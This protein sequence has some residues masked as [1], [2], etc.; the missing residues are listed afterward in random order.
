MFKFHIK[1]FAACNDPHHY[2]SSNPID[3][4]VRAETMVEAL[5][6]AENALGYKIH[7][8]TMTVTVEED[9]SINN[10]QGNSEVR[11]YL[12]KIAAL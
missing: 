11:A 1:G 5:V 12:K 6:K 7:R 3:I 2:S 9:Y 4:T 10:T 8:N